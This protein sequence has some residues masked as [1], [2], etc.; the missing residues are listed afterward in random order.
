LLVAI[1]VD[2]H[3]QSASEADQCDNRSEGC[4]I[5]PKIH[6][7]DFGLGEAVGSFDGGFEGDSLLQEI[8]MPVGRGNGV[9]VFVGGGELNSL[10]CEGVEG[11]EEEVFTL[12]GKA[13]YVTGREPVVEEDGSRD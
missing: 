11:L 7:A 3:H 10:A 2:A 13:F 6:D 12:K 4:A 8:E 5:G 1:V 9:E